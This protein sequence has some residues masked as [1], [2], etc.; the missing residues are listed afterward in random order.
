MIFMCLLFSIIFTKNFFVQKFGLTINVHLHW[1]IKFFVGQSHHTVTQANALVIAV[2]SK[3]RH[4]SSWCR[5][6]PVWKKRLLQV[7]E[8][9]NRS[10]ETSLRGSSSC[11]HHYDISHH[12]SRGQK[13]AAMKKKFSK[14]E[15]SLSLSL[16]HLSLMIMK[17][18]NGKVS[19]NTGPV[20][21]GKK[22]KSMKWVWEGMRDTEVHVN[23][24][25]VRE[26]LFLLPSSVLFM[27]V[28]LLHWYWSLWPWSLPIA[29]DK[30]W[31]QFMMADAAGERTWIRYCG[32]G[33]NV[34]LR[35]VKGN[36]GTS[37]H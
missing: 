31:G 6:L 16:F 12:Q 14:A 37:Y 33:I 32:G 13:E 25:L 24:I 7:N 4:T 36:K 18:V 8:C 21:V 1:A 17:W 27:S 11:Q 9:Q 10:H 28:C 35:Q 3:R 34:S 23:Y 20:F 26:D 15:I 5:R 30:S 22:K 29:L 2:A 19:Q